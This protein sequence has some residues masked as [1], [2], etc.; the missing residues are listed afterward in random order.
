MLGEPLTPGDR[1]HALKRIAFSEN[2]NIAGIDKARTREE[3]VNALLESINPALV[4][5]PPA[6]TLQY[7]QPIDNK[8]PMGDEIRQ[9]YKHQRVQQL[10]SQKRELK[11]WWLQQIAQKRSPVAERLLVFWHN[12]YTTELRK[13][14][15]PLM[16]RQHML[17][18][19]HMLGSYSDLMAA[20]IKN[21]ALL[22]YLDNQ[23]NRKGNPNENFARE[24]LELYTLGEGHYNESDIKELARV[25]TG[26]SFQARS[27]E[28]QFFQNQHDNGEK[29]LLGK[30]GTYQPIDITDL[31][32]AHP[33][34]AEHLIEKLWQA[35][36]SPT[37]NEIA[38]KRLAVYFRE[39]DYSLYSLLHKLWLEPA[40]WENA[41]RYSLV[42]SPL[43]YVANLH[44]RN[45]ISLKP[46][47]H[48][49]R[50][51]EE[52]GQ[53]LFDPPD[54]GGWPEGRDWINSSR[55]IN[56]ERY[57]RQFASRMSLQLPESD[58]LEHL[59]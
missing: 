17:L 6:W 38:I 47:D 48:L 19:Q 46:S 36:I 58:E 16:W 2:T 26:A 14:H 29:T 10:R 13:V 57:R 27:G 32:L 31:L 20:I 11:S 23:K 54:V 59:K 3:L 34:A 52:M 25:F 51:L 44:W 1:E 53:D 5:V 50:D 41:N 55:L 9:L 35:Y 42:K 22:R 28:Y 40:F 7:P 12:F 56:R 37:P 45:D 24:L 15:G 8:W 33:R 18:R 43:E 49:I 39:Q 30:T 21:P 4:V